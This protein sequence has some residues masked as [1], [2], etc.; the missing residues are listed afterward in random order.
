VA[1]EEADSIKNIRLF[2]GVGYKEGL[3]EPEKTLG[4]HMVVG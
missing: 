1:A 2:E 3:L 4:I